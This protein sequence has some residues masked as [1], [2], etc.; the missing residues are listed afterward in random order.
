M[1]TT[2][3]FDTTE[4]HIYLAAKI[5]DRN[6]VEHTFRGVLD[7]GAPSTEFSDE[8]LLSVGILE[9]DL[10]RKVDIHPEQ[11]TARYGRVVLPRIYCLGQTMQNTRVKVVRFVEGWAVDALIGLDF[12]RKFEVRINYKLGSITTELL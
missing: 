7:T 1:L 4:H 6:G 2:T 11:Q 3:T 5:L 9:P 10:V 12:F 8:F